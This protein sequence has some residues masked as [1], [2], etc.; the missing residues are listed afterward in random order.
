MGIIDQK[1]PSFGMLD[2]EDVHSTRCCEGADGKAS[3]KKGLN[4][5]LTHTPC[6]PSIG[7]PNSMMIVLWYFLKQKNHDRERVK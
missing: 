5:H 2:Y 3:Q 4:L 7:Y 1:T 6:W